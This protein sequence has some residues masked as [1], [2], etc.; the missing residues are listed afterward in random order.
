VYSI[1][2]VVGADRRAV[3]SARVT[4]EAIRFAR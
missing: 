1:G 4:V 2:D 3:E